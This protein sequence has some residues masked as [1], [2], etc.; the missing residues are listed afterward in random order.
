M[1][2]QDYG[3]ALVTGASSG[4]G[5]AT[6]RLLAGRGLTV[7]AVARRA[8]RLAELTEHGAVIPHALDMRDRAAL[9]E[10]FG[11]L[12]VDILVNSAGVGS[13]FDP[14]HELDPDKIDATLDTNVAGT[15]HA[16]RALSP[17]MVARARGHIV[18]IGSIFGLHAIST[19]VYGASKAAVHRLSQ[20][21]RHD[22]KGTGIRVTEVSPGRAATEI[23]ATMTDDTAA[24][25]AMVDGFEIITADDVAEAVV[26]A[27]D[28]P[29][30]V[31][32]SLIEL[33][34][35]EQIP[36]GVTIHPV[37]GRS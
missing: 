4:I 32:V 29:W 20:D 31:N 7:H 14:F 28:Q 10:L 22:L 26:W 3:T 33:T 24:Q 18:N 21:L 12:E 34:A 9:Y 19:A 15:V 8:E 27:L 5:A 36:G 23:F 17:G 25:G 35:T 2:L 37:P 16:A 6:V 13:Q 11:G 1:A 30:R